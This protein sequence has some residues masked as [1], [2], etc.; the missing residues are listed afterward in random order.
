M[1]MN[2]AGAYGA[3]PAG[4][5]L[6]KQQRQKPSMIGNAFG[7][8]GNVWNNGLFGNTEPPHL[9]SKHV[10]D[11]IEKPFHQPESWM[12][13]TPNTQ[14]STPFSPLN[15]PVN[16]GVPYGAE[17]SGWAPDGV[18]GYAPDGAPIYERSIAR[19]VPMPMPGGA[20]FPQV[21]ALPQYQQMPG[22]DP[23]MQPRS[24]MNMPGVLNQAGGLM[25]Q[26]FSGLSRN[27][28][29][30]DAMMR[31]QYDQAMSR[32]GSM[33]EGAAGPLSQ[34]AG[35]FLPPAA[36]QAVQQIGQN[37]SAR[38]GQRQQQMWDMIGQADQRGMARGQFADQ[39]SRYW[40]PASPTNQQRGVENQLKYQQ[41]YTNAMNASTGMYNAQSTR[42]NNDNLNQRSIDKQAFEE[43]KFGREQNLAEGE[44]EEKIRQFNVTSK[45][46]DMESQVKAQEI[47]R[48]LAQDIW[49]QKQEHMK[50]QM[51]LDQYNNTLLDKYGTA[52]PKQIARVA[53]DKYTA[54]QEVAR[55]QAQMA[56]MEKA[57]AAV[58]ARL[59]ALA[60]AATPHK[61]KDKDGKDVYLSP[62]DAPVVR[63]QIQTMLGNPMALYAPVQQG[64]G[65]ASKLKASGMTK[66]QAW[67]QYKREHGVK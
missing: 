25:G 27:A 38:P 36:A 42:M 57:Q 9:F 19:N 53:A 26:T 8:I 41:N 15:L 17:Q 39:Y 34:I 33:L 30:E 12:P 67:E 28:G 58:N 4:M 43:E 10:P 44:F 48:G 1:Q 21:P 61:T 54:Q 35:A 11:P 2:Y 13:E 29:M 49:K 20:P 66:E 62:L 63:D 47:S 65:L 37:I 22:L 40:D 7:A 24:A 3:P 18:S 51:Q 55:Q 45:Q 50:L 46:K 23:M 31:R 6:Q 32:N 52:D 59:E 16:F 60:K 64:N 14:A 56:Q 5:P